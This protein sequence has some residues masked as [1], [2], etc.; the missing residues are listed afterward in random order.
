[1][2][3]GV[4][5]PARKKNDICGLANV[6]RSHLQLSCAYVKIES[7]YEVLADI[8][9]FDFEIVS[10]SE[11]GNDHGRTHPDKNLIQIREDVYDAA[12][13]GSG[14]DRFTMAHELGHF[15][16]HRNVQFSRTTVSHEIYED[17]EWQADVFASALLIDEKHLHKC[18]SVQEVSD[19]FGVTHAAARC[20]FGK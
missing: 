8:L 19:T 1:M 4:K 3:N 2:R 5:V 11:L 10:K 6:L 13:K 15:F 7:V 9:D 20:R 16:L 14:R 12:C 17:S 18:R